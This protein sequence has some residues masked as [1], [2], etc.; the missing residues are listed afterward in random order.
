MC[1]KGG[2]K[3]DARRYR[4]AG[5]M[6]TNHC[7]SRS[8]KRGGEGGVE[9]GGREVKCTHRLARHAERTERFP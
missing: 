8:Q 4:P 3:K 2:E 6:K 7:A 9:W 1:R 5:G